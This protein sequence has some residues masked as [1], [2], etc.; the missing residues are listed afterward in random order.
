[1]VALHIVTVGRSRL[2]CNSEKYFGGFVQ[3]F[4]CLE[5]CWVGDGRWIHDYYLSPEYSPVKVLDVKK[6]KYYM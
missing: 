3:S 1:V 5:G 6:Q 4:F 2:T